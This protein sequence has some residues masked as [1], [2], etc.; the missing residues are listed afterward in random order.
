[1][2]THLPQVAGTMAQAAGQPF[3]G[4]SVITN[5]VDLIS[6]RCALTVRRWA[7]SGAESNDVESDET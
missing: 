4:R 2:A 7:E 3:A 6:Q 5:I 1:M